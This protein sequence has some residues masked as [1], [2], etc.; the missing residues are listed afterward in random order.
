[1][2]GEIPSFLLHLIESRKKIISMFS[3]EV[4]GRIV[5]IGKIS[6]QGVEGKWGEQ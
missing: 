5:S 4:Y 1:M 2:K 6:N 3:L